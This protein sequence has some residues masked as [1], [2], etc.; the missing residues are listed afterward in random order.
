MK[1]SEYIKKVQNKEID[2]VSYT[3]EV[4]EKIKKLNEEY[5]C[6]IEISEELALKQAEKISKDPKGKLAGVF[7]SVKDSICVKDVNSTGGSRILEGYKPPFNA[8]AVQNCV[9]EGAIIIGKTSQ[10]EFGFG[11]FSVNVG[12]EYKIP[13]NPIDKTRA[14]GGSSGGAACI[15]ALAD[16]PHISLGESTG[17]SIVNP[18]SFCGVLALCPTYGRVSR[19]GLIDYGNSLDK[20]G[21]IG[22]TAE[23]VAI[24]METIA[25][26]D[27]KDSTSID[28][29]I[30]N[31]L[32]KLNSN[33][34]GMKIGL[35]KESLDS[36]TDKNV[37]DVFNKQ[38]EFLK[39]KGAVVEEVSLKK[40]IDYGI[41]AYYVIGTSEASTNLAKYCGMRYGKEDE[42]KGTFNEYFTNVRSKY[43]GDEAK[44]RIMLGTFTR[45]S[46]YRDAY[47]IKAMK[48]RTLIIDEYK[49]AFEKFDVLISPTTPMIAP[50]FD[51]I[52]KMTPL[53]HYMADVL[54]V[55]PNLAGLPH[56]NIPIETETMPVG[57]MVTGNHFD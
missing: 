52:E 11:A 26:Y 5:D 40:A 47:Y 24:G 27:K 31:Y 3:K 28:K 44:R 49:K 10:D 37:K 39:S 4:L 57:F 45:T 23:D 21:P 30:P 51:E 29:E 34:N 19:Y 54:T 38:I 43:L 35:I 7:V 14:T 32:E 22:K 2:I 42:L 36:G 12:V 17:G 16:F 8:T 1:I 18:G 13:K 33:I 46:G 41:A 56:I 20:V 9:D 15:T 6:L 55:G 50:R 25:S 48:I 53:Q